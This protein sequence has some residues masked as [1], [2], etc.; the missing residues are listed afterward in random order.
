VSGTRQALLLGALP[1]VVG[2]VYW[3]L[4]QTRGTVAVVDAAGATMLVALGLAMG[5]GMLVI[6]RGARD[7]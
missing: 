7:L 3:I 4:Q 5:F 2:V 6:L 1:I